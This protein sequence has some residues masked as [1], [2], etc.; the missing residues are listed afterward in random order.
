MSDTA[1]KQTYTPASTALDAILPIFFHTDRSLAQ[2]ISA[3]IHPAAA[4]V[5]CVLTNAADEE[6]G[7]ASRVGMQM[8]LRFAFDREDARTVV[9][10]G[11]EKAVKGG[12]AEAFESKE[13]GTLYRLTAAGKAMM[14][15]HLGSVF[16]NG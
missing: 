8:G 14:V 12:L 9:E 2:N 10:A 5:L 7:G 3:P 4:V 11:I 16:K 13:G 6:E 1:E 15:D